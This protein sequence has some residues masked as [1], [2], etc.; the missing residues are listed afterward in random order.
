MIM[1]GTAASSFQLPLQPVQI[2]SNNIQEE[3]NPFPIRVGKKQKL[4]YK[5]GERKRDGME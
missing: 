1:T 3:D 2:T 4:R 5:D